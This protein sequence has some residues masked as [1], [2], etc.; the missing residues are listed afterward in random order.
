[1][2]P[3]GGGRCLGKNRPGG[4][5]FPKARVWT[6]LEKLWFRPQGDRD[7]CWFTWAGAG[8]R[9]LGKQHATV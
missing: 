9:S 7:V 6:P 5:P 4:D 2:V 3:E 1:M 8:L